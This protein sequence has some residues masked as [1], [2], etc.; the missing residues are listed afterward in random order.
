MDR[1]KVAYMILHLSSHA[2]AWAMVEWGGWEAARALMGIRQ[3]RHRVADYT[4]EFCTL[5]V[6]SGWKSFFFNR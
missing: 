4:T 5:A 2:K 3:G 1:V 6:D